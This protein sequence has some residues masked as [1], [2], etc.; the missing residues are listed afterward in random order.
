MIM[1]ETHRGAGRPLR[2]RFRDAHSGLAGEEDTEAEKVGPD[3]VDRG[4][5]RLWV[6]ETETLSPYTIS[7]Y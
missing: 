6:P 7:Y 4:A 5:P 2:S 1:E 3:L